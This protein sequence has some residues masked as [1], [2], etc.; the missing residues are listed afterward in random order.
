VHRS[1][2]ISLDNVSGY[3]NISLQLG[4][5]EIPIGRLYKQAVLERL[6]LH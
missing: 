1:Y 6:Q 2:I 4:G 3:N 5:H